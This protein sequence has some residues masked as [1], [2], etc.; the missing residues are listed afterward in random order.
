MLWTSFTINLKNKIMKRR[1]FIKSGL[2][3]TMAAGATG[4]SAFGEIIAPSE[5]NLNQAEMERFINDLDISM[6]RISH[7]GGD[8]FKNLI[9]Q[10]PSESE[11]KIFRSSLRSLMLVGSF[12][13]L[14]IKGQVHPQMQ[15]RMMYSASEVN[16]S[17]NNSLGLLKNMSDESKE[18]IRYALTEDRRLG[19]QILDTLDLEAISIGVPSA[20]RRQMKVMGRRIIRRMRHSPEMLIDE[21]VNKTEKLLL[22][23]NSDK[24]F[25]RMFKMQVGETRYSSCLK[26]AESAARQWEKSN[27]PDMA[28][29]YGLIT[30]DQE[31]DEEPKLSKSP[32]FLQGLRLL[33]IGAITTAAGGL[34]IA[35][36]M[37][38]IPILSEVSFIVG[39]VLGVT[40][41]PILILIALI[42]I[43]ISAI[44]FA[45]KKLKSSE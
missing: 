36:G 25:E 15:K 18:E 6:E 28:V 40:V 22:A 34:L 26:E 9:S 21:Y 39:V 16:F 45:I 7:S 43:I 14:P 5:E 24:A 11:E 2:V 27:V 20:R 44:I 37:L 1:E 23:S 13:D 35:I 42:V 12:G 4:H 41:G 31:N 30:D 10:T 32:V 3:L 38:P 19:R 33:G 29:G 17:V 8:H